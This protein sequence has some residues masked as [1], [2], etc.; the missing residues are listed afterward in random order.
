MADP[1]L[2]DLTVYDTEGTRWAVIQRWLK[3]IEETLTAPAASNARLVTTMYNVG[4]ATLNQIFGYFKA[5]AATTITRAQVFCQTGP[6]GSNLNITLVNGSGTSLGSIAV[7][8]DGA[9]V[10]ETVFGAPLV[11]A[12][13]D[14]VRC[15]VTAVGATTN[16]GYVTVNLL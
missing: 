10:Q 12:A 4:D 13:G 14:V 15:K 1:L 8:A 9:E 6:V 2:R 11:L 7:V 3:S 16:G 5:P